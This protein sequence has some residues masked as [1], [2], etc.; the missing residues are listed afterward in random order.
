MTVP[1]SPIL[2]LTRVSD[3]S[4][5]A[6]CTIPA[7][8]TGQLYVCDLTTSPANLGELKTSGITNQQTV[9]LSSLRV[10]GCFSCSLFSVDGSGNLSLPY[11]A[12]VSLTSSTSVL[13]AVHNWW[14]LY[15]TLTQNAG[16][17]YTQ[18]AFENLNGQDVTPPYTVITAE[19]SYIAH[20]FEKV[21]FEETTL[22]FH[23]YALGLTA[24]ETACAEIR[25]RFDFA[26]VVFPAGSNV[27]TVWMRPVNYLVD[28]TLT[29]YRDGSYIFHAERVYE[30][31]V[32]RHEASN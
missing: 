24:A 17:L 26:R 12:F 1:A 6:F 27:F 29:R 14:G 8:C 18:E 5:T 32:Q 23:S 21:S 20:A 30:M 25:D 4:L 28:N 15:P 7:G 19:R 31:M 3:T 2:N 10:A 11:V 16:Q 22:S 9:T 13:G